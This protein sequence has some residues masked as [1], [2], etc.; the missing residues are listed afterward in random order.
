MKKCIVL[1]FVLSLA[2]SVYSTDGKINFFYEGSAQ[3][4]ILTPQGATIYIDVNDVNMLQKKVPDTGDILLTTHNHPDHRS[5]D[6]YPHF[7]GKQIFIKK[8]VIKTQG[9]KITSIPSS[10]D[11]VFDKSTPIDAV[12]MFI[13]LI[14]IDKIKIAHFG[15]IGQEQLLPKQVRLLKNV[16]IAFAQLSNSYS[17]MDIEN[18]K[19]FNIIDQINPKVI[20]PLHADS[21][22]ELYALTKYKSYFSEDFAVSL[23]KTDIPKTPIFLIMGKNKELIDIENLSNSGK[24]SLF[25]S[26]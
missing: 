7:P 12:F 1:L 24:I 17:Q 3:V 23:S 21:A 9:I 20:I 6:F 11:K 25:K 10:H 18:K 4:E 5:S 15:D 16:D 19:G 8:G 26:N 13:Y 14:E 2:F 22:T